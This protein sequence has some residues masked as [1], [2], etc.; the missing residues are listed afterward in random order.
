MRYETTHVDGSPTTHKIIYDKLLEEGWSDPI[1]R[2]CTLGGKRG[3]WA[4][5]SQGGEPEYLGKEI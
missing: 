5:E 2:M 4:W 1:I 3:W